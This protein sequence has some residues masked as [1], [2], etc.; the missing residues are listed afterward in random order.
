[1]SI[2]E[3]GAVVEHISEMSW[4]CRLDRLAQAIPQWQSQG[5]GYVGAMRVGTE[6]H[7]M[8]ESLWYEP[9]GVLTSH[10]YY[11][12]ASGCMYALSREAVQLVTRVPLS[13]RRLAGGTDDATVG[14]WVLGY[15][16]PYLDDWRLSVGLSED[17]SCP[18]NFVGER[19]LQ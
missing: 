8:K 3:T 1:M 15:N 18:D 7:A 14:L 16:I 13:Q 12:Y 2:A 6:A 11:M 9:L 17:G 5:S 19:K 4:P 10:K